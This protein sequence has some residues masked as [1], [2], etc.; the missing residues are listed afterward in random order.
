VMVFKP[1]VNEASIGSRLL[2]SRVLAKHE[3]TWKV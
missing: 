3:H 2:L 1:T